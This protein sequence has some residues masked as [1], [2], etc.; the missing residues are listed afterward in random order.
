MCVLIHIK[1]IVG[2]VG[3]IA[4]LYYPV[5]MFSVFVRHIYVFNGVKT[6]AVKPEAHPIQSDFEYRIARRLIVEVKLGHSRTEARKVVVPV[7]ILEPLL[8]F[9]APFLR[10]FVYAVDI[11]L[12]L[13]SVEITVIYFFLLAIGKR[14]RFFHKF[15]RLGKPRI[16]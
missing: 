6:E 2:V 7:G 14:N 13:P 1:R 3:F 11:L 16:G 5:G 15:L 9:S 12:V 4:I 10:A 8:F